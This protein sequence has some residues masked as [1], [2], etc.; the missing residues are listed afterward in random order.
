MMAFDDSI[1]TGLGIDG[2]AKENI[3]YK[4]YER[5]VGEKPKAINKD[6]LKK[7]IDKHWQ[8]LSQD[9]KEHL[10]PYINKYL[11]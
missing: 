11:N 6:A 8:L 4:N 1:L 5:R 2:E 10:T 9:E 3:F 7:Y